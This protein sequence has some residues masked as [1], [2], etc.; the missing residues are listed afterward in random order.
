[1]IDLKN[2]TFSVRYLKF[3]VTNDKS[4][5]N[6]ISCCITFINLSVIVNMKKEHARNGILS[7]L[8]FLLVLTF[9]TCKKDTASG[10]ISIIGK[11]SNN[12]IGNR[13]VV[14]Q[15][16]FK[17]NDS[18]IFYTYKIDTLTK[19][20]IGYG[21]RS[22][23]NYKIE[24]STLTMYNMVNFSNPAGNFV[25][26]DQLVQGGGSASEMYTFALNNQKHQLSLYFTCPP[27]ADCL[28]SPIIYFKQ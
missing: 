13:D 28:P 4:S 22:I 21:Y 6:N 20:V 5:N 24:K 25:P 7:L 1:M 23:G 18:V 10:S 2:S 26:V 3:F 27:N 12:L 16:E 17:S 15:Y 9:S 11:W 19:S 14:E 8:A